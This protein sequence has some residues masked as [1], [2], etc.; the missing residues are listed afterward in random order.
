MAGPGQTVVQKGRYV[1]TVDVPFLLGAI[2]SPELLKSKLE[3]KGF[4][5]VEVAESRPP[6]WPLSADGDYYVSVG[7]LK[8]PKLF[9]VPDA[10]TEYRKVG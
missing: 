9:D 2:V 8:S 3:E 6:G 10:V 1:A 4:T 7:W 5:S